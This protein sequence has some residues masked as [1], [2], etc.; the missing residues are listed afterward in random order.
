MTLLDV[1][2]IAEYWTEH[3]PTHLL[4]AAYIGFNPEPTIEGEGDWYS[5]LPPAPGIAPG[6]LP[7]NLPEPILDF[8]ALM[9]MR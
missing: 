9:R 7:A 6:K 4:M 2:E 8:D 3:P 5:S 1:K